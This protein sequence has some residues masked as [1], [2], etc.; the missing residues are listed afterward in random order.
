M[1]TT[2]L[3]PA[4][5]LRG[6]CGGRVHLPGDPG[7]DAARTPW[8]LAVDQRPAAVAVPHSAE[9]VAEVVRAAA[10]AGLRVAPQSSGHGAGPLGER[11]LEDV[12]L[13][14]LNELTGVTVDP[15]ARVARVLGGTL[16]QEVI[17][18]SAPHGLTALH[19]SSPDVAV[20]GYVLGG[21]LSF[22]GRRHGLATNSLRAVELVTADGALVRAS[23]DEN[24]E[25]FWAVRGGSGN[26][27]VAVA[28]EVELLPY[29]EVYAGM[30]LWDRERA[31]AV[32]RA[33]A[34][35]TADLPESVTT[36]LRVMSFPPLP[37]LPPFLSGRRIVVIDGAVL[38]DDDRAAELLAPLRAL[39]PEMDTF[40]RI[41]S[42]GLV[43]VHM[44]PPAPVP[45]VA[46]HAVLAALPEEAV[47]AYLAEVG[48]GSDTSLLFAE[49]RHLGGALGRPAENGGVA[50]HLEGGYAL[51]CCAMAPFP[52]AAAQGRADALAACAALAPWTTG[53]RVTNFTETVADVSSMY[54]DRWERLRAVKAAVDPAGRFV[55]HHPVG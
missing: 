39:E 52:A 49:L 48:P 55:G 23:A 31:P 42:A 38:E 33:W 17:D 28:F 46:D 47:A 36:S 12:V 50:S 26:F 35:W 27:G 9:E 29:A 4:D 25:L 19:G 53:T 14:R 2:P 24:A 10:A 7:Y 43:H 21:G 5:D 11:G 32:V 20:A 6:L 34:A 30:L 41:P 44:D 40:A 45:A 1:T 22:Y 18:A 8:N 54:G 15:G 13:V 37:D 3:S 51:F 16:W